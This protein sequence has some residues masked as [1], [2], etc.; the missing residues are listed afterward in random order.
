MKIV[1]INKMPILSS[2]G[3]G[4][5]H[6]LDLFL[7]RPLYFGVHKSIKDVNHKEKY[8]FTNFV[9]LLL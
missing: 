9:C 3:C 6:D 4:C 5:E 7:Q 2:L 1:T 8:Q